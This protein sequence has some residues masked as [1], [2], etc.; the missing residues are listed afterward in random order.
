MLSTIKKLE[1]H[2]LNGRIIL[3]IFSLELL[4]IQPMPQM[5]PI[6]KKEE[7]L[8]LILLL[9]TLANSAFGLPLMEIQLTR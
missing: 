9:P 8:S 6:L 2:L 5:L 1:L 7:N 3:K 4:N